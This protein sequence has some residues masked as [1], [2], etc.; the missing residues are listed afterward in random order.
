MK[1]G[2]HTLPSLR[3]QQAGPTQSQREAIAR[4]FPCF[5][6]PQVQ[7]LWPSLGATCPHVAFGRWPRRVI[8]CMHLRC[9][10]VGD[11]SSTTLCWAPSLRH[12]WASGIYRLS[13]A[14]YGGSPAIEEA[15]ITYVF[16]R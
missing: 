8:L 3:L 10:S 5:A 14:P 16:R 7:R 2:A 15:T 1:E 6:H 11:D 13:D 4:L 9:G 12:C